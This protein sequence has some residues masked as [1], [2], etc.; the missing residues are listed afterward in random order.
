MIRKS[1][2]MCFIFPSL[3]METVLDNYCLT[4]ITKIVTKEP[5]RQKSLG[6]VERHSYILSKRFQMF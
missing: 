6:H 1:K 3:L 2:Y 5:K 4:I